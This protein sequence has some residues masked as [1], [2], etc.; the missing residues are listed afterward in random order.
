MRVRQSI[1]KEFYPE[2]IF[3]NNTDIYMKLSR[4][5]L[6]PHA[7]FLDLNRQI[8]PLSG[9]LI[10]LSSSDGL[11]DRI[12]HLSSYTISR[13]FAN[14]DSRYLAGLAHAVRSQKA[15]EMVS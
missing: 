5:I 13:D 3:E 10:D 12:F 7:P 1:E 11:D 15:R 4:A 2:V 6:E 14:G 8:I 9:D